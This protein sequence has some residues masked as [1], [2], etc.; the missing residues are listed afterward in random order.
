MIIEA[1]GT[2][3]LIIWHPEA[4]NSLNPETGKVYWSVKQETVNGTS[5]MAPRVLD[6]QL[7]VGAWMRKA[8]L[9][10]LEADK[11]GAKR[12]WKG[13]RDS[14]VYPISSTPF[15]ENGHIYGVCTEGELRCVNI[16]DGERI[17]ET[18]KPVAGE[19]AGSANAHLVKH[20]DR[21]FITAETG[22]LIIAKLSP[23]G[24]DEVSRWHMQ[25]P[26]AKAFGREVY[27]AHPAF[28]QK[29][30]F[31]RNDKELICAS[32]AK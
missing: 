7:F 22:D 20:G 19:K 6:S 17:W 11:P 14:A 2:R 27:W 23:K 9:L 26:T 12:I 30:I 29:C 10:Q 18:Y 4:I 5:I 1:G 25:E 24:Y 15:L 16:K 32:L 3:Q 21:F 31:A 28:A 8:A 13:D